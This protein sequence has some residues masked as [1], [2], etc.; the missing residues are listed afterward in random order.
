MV[1]IHRLI[2]NILVRKTSGRILETFKQINALL[3]I[4]KCKTEMYFH[5]IA[6]LQEI[7]KSNVYVREIESNI[8]C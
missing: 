5:I 7:R 8:E 1:H 6:S 4:G 2:G 3:D